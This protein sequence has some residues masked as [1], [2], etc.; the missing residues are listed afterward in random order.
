MMCSLLACGVRAAGWIV[1]RARWEHCA[2]L[3][4]NLAC[5]PVKSPVVCRLCWLVASGGWLLLG[6]Y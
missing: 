5:K 2:G 1:V 6:A 4:F 3:R